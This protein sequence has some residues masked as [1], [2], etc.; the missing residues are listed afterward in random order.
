MFPWSNSVDL[1][2]PHA[3]TV[4]IEM[5]LVPFLVACVIVIITLIRS[6]KN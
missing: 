5:V 6:R 4:V 3:L 1:G 2:M